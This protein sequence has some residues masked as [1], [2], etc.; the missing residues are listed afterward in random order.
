MGEKS[1]YKTLGDAVGMPDDIDKERIRRIILNYEKKHP[2]WIAHARDEAK[3]DFFQQGGMK[4]KFGEVNKQAGGRVVFELPEGL[5]QQLEEYI[6][7][8]FR[9]KKHFQWFVKNFKELM[10]PESY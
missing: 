3:R 1:T 8:L 10:V 2:G 9:E 5:H 6:P 4:Q 7:T